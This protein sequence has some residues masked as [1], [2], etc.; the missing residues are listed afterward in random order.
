MGPDRLAAPR[1]EV[2]RQLDERLELGR[3]LVPKQLAAAPTADQLLAAL[4]RW[5]TTTETAIDNLFIGTKTLTSYRNS[6]RMGLYVGYESDQERVTD[7]LDRHERRLSAL[8]AIIDG[9]AYMQEAGQHPQPITSSVRARDDR[10]VTINLQSGNVNLGT[11][12]GDVTSNV[13]GLTGPDAE[14]IKVLMAR[15][16]G[17]VIDADLN[18]DDKE[19]AGE[20]V[21]VVSE[22]LKAGTGHKPSAMVRSALRRIPL[23]L[24]TADQALKVWSDLQGVIGPHLPPGSM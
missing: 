17:A 11:V 5:S 22:A 24:Q 6:G 1:A 20:A 3:G 15:L 18:P 9:L 2:Q 14:T 4:D 16:A 12:V 23:L 8:E 21:E 10:A 19:E 7:G 13:S